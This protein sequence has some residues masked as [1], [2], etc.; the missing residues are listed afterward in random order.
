MINL[1]RWLAGEGNVKRHT[2]HASNQGQFRWKHDRVHL[3]KYI[4]QKRH[5]K[6]G[7]KANK[8]VLRYG[9][10]HLGVG[11]EKVEADT[12]E[13]LLEAVRHTGNEGVVAG[14]ASVGG[15]HNNTTPGLL[16]V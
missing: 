10:L 13:L 2:Q 15:A 8:P 3:Q 16:T 11:V 1:K 6:T 9:Y 5:Q 14:N 7:T 4:M 12:G